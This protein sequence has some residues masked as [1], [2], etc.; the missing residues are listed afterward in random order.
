MHDNL[1]R[2]HQAI[3]V[4]P[5]LTSPAQFIYVRLVPVGSSR[6]AR[7]SAVLLLGLLVLGSGLVWATPALA[8]PASWSA[9]GNLSTPR[10]YTVATAL[11]DGKV[12]VSGG[13]SGSTSLATTELYDPATNAW[14]S[15]GTMVS[16]RRF[17]TATLL[18]N[19]KVLVAG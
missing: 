6:A 16:A 12:L 9:T 15:A 10:G 11:A 14:S 2:A 18:P 7:R 17:H 8:I 13:Y 19:G 4:R 1:E 5:S 3:A